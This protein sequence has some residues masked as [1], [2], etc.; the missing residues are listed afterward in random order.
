MTYSEKWKTHYVSWH[1]GLVAVQDVEILE[2]IAALVA[3]WWGELRIMQGGLSFNRLSAGTHGGFGV[4]D[5]Q[6]NGRRPDGKARTKEDVLRLAGI[7]LQCGLVFFVRGYG[8]GLVRLALDFFRNNRHGHVVSRELYGPGMAEGAKKQ[9]REFDRFR[10]D[11]RRNP[12]GDG[13]VGSHPYPGPVA[14][15]F[16]RWADS[17]LNPANQAPP[18]EDLGLYYCTVKDGFL[19]GLDAARNKVPGWELDRGESVQAYQ[20]APRWGR[21]NIVTAGGRWYAAEFLSLTPPS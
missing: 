21:D 13:L 11:P 8:L 12:D 1:G 7:F 3:P 9:Y 20:R 19:Y 10:T 4:Y 5:V 6:T 16:C 18:V 15:M 17:S 14:S 2:V